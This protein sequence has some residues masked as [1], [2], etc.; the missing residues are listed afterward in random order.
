MSQRILVPVDYSEHSR[1]VL[2]VALTLAERLGAELDVLHVWESMPQFPADWTVST[3]DGGRR[4]LGELVQEC[5]EREM[6]EFLA[7]NLPRGA[8]VSHRVIPGHA[9]REILER[10]DPSSYRMVVI[11]THGRGGL[12]HFTLGSVAERVLRLSPVPVITVP[13]RRRTMRTAGLGSGDTRQG[14]PGA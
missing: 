7:A 3:P 11:G 5:A 9:V 2:S 10:L 13:E 8:R 1:E 4:P 6:Q 14:G 12:R